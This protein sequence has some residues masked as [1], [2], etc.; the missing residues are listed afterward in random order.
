[1]LAQRDGSVATPR[2]HTVRAAAHVT[3]RAA[4]RGRR[5]GRPCPWRG[6]RCTTGRCPPVRGGVDERAGRQLDRG[7]DSA[8]SAITVRPLPWSSLAAAIRSEAGGARTRLT[9]CRRNTSGCNRR[10]RIPSNHAF[11]RGQPVREQLRHR[12]SPAE[13]A[14][15]GQRREISSRFR[16]GRPR[17]R[18]TT[19]AHRASA[20]RFGCRGTNAAFA[21]FAWSRLMELFSGSELY[22]SSFPNQHR[23]TAAGG[24]GVASIGPFSIALPTA[25]DQATRARS[26]S[27]TPGASMAAASSVGRCTRAGRHRHS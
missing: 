18:T 12:A 26:C 6:E 7:L 27:P 19:T 3:A 11:D 4:A 9:T 2:R 22:T 15:Q 20:V 5:S 16:A 8:P 21:C 13:T 25:T 24:V 14:G 17:R 23:D 1:M 10:A